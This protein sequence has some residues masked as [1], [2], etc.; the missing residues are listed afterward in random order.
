M[1]LPQ[2]TAWLTDFRTAQAVFASKN[3]ARIDHYITLCNTGKLF[4]CHCEL[5]L[6]KA[7]PTLAP[8]FLNG[9]NT[10]IK[11]DNAIMS[12]CNSASKLP[13]ARKLLAGNWT[14][15]FLSATA[16][17]RNYGV[18]CDTQPGP[19]TS[20]KDICDHYGLYI[21]DAMDYFIEVGI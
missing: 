14:P 1:S 12:N 6:F 9:H 18:I 4:I 15:L 11:P 16:A 21:Y 10:V 3:N 19:Y 13:I 7:D 5:D 20:T 8:V 17:S 2:V